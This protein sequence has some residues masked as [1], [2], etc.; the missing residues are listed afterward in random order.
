M[1]NIA[2][3]GT[4]PEISLHIN[5][6]VYNL[7]VSPEVSLLDVLRDELGL[8]GTKKGCNAGDCGACTVLVDGI[9]MNSC[10]LLAIRL[11]NNEITTIE[12]L[13]DNDALHQ[14]QK[15]FINAGAIQCGYCTPGM[16]LSTKSLL[17]ENPTPTI[18]DIKDALAGNL[19]RC[20]GYQKIIE[21]IQTAAHHLANE[22]I[23]ARKQEE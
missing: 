10:L 9:A 14:I 5:G 17:D 12:G 6:K 19:C 2:W 21:S 20:T 7:R 13:S 8:I 16:V 18:D 22:K 1:N 23:S 4:N 3:V 15:A 11:Q